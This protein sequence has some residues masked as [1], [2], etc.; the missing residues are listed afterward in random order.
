MNKH[1]PVPGGSRNCVRCRWFVTEPHHLPAMTAHFNTLA[2]HFDE[3]RNACIAHEKTLQDLKKQKA[4]AEE[5]DQPFARIDAY[6]Q[7]ERMWEKSL[8]RFSDL[9]EDLVACWRLIERCKVAL[10][11]PLGDGTQLIAAGTV[12]DVSIV[13]E[14]TESELLQLVGVCESVEIYPDLE[15]GKA[16]FR[17][18]QLLDAVLYRDNLSPMFMLLSEQEQLLAGNAFIRHLA[19]KMNPENPTLGQRQVINLIDAGVNLSTHF[20]L[21]LATLLTPTE[22]PQAASAKHRILVGGEK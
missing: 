5:E 12:G 20:D 3:A 10:D 16:V 19:Q 14:E 2:Y 17:R 15:P 1:G 8:K 7:A 22:T 6:R 9:A 11:A 4:D 18:S 13:F 21:D